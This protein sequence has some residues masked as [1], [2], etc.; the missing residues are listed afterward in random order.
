[1]RLQS[2]IGSAKQKSLM[3]QGVAPHSD[4]VALLVLP[5]MGNIRQIVGD[6]Q[7]FL[8]D[9]I[10]GGSLRRNFSGS[11]FGLVFSV[12]HRLHLC[13]DQGKDRHLNAE[14]EPCGGQRR[15]TRAER[16]IVAAFKKGQPFFLV[17]MQCGKG[18][19]MGND[20]PA[21]FGI[22]PC[23][24]QRNDR[25]AAVAEYK[26]GGFSAG[27]QYCQN[28][29]RLLGQIKSFGEIHGASGVGPAVI[30]DDFAGPGQCVCQRQIQI[31]GTAASGNEQKRRALAGDLV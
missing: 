30:G 5:D 19:F 28:V 12:L 9:Q 26:S 7:K 31:T 10:T 21:G 15:S 6:R 14:Q 23:K 13:P 25:T 17:W 24:F 4:E 11:G 1:M 29:P 8:L 3:L 18:R 16:G 27:L 22:K 20:A 2:P